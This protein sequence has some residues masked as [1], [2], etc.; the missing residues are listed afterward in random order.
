MKMGAEES[1]QLERYAPSRQ[2]PT[3]NVEVVR[4]QAERREVHTGGGRLSTEQV[5]I[6]QLSSGPRHQ[7][8]R[9]SQTER[10]QI[11]INGSSESPAS[12]GLQWRSPLL[13][14][15]DSDDDSDNDGEC[16]YESHGPGHFIQRWYKCRTC[17]GGES[18][19][20][21]CAHCA[22]TCHPGHELVSDGLASAECD[23]GH[24]KH[25]QS[26]CTWHVTRKNYVGQPFYRCY[27][28]FSGGNEGVCYQCMRKCHRGHN[29][30]FVGTISAF[31]DCGLDCCRI[32][33][34][35]A[36]PR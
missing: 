12:H 10:V 9:V 18:Q 19:F 5:R 21:C 23:C 1:R 35:I 6:V 16:T 13:A 25:Q 30:L 26:V 34:S 14:L 2:E 31:C 17:W 32:N 29:T 22:E 36:S 11:R 28:C 7:Q 4:V 24:N 20:G 15:Q 3:H 33:C 8:L 27:D